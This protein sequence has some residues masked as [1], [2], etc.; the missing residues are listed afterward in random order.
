LARAA[1]GFA[2]AAG[3]LRDAVRGV[4]EDSPLVAELDRL[5][6]SATHLGEEGRKGTPLERSRQE[7]QKLQAA[8]ERAL[9]TLKRDHD[10]HHDEHV[11]GDMKTLTATF[12]RLLAQV[13]GRRN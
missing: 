4:S 12:D 10:V 2:E 5:A 13:S 7:F 9:A 1:S 8:Y 11:A 3:H 6:Q